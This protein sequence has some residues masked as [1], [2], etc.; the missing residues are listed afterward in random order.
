MPIVSVIMPSFNTA[1][2]VRASV[3][4]VLAQSF[5][6][7][8]LIVVDDG[9]KDGS[10][11][12]VRE[13][14]LQDPRINLLARDGNLGPSRARNDG[15]RVARGEFIAFCDSDDLWKPNKLEVQ[16]GLLR[17]NPEYD[18]TYC[19]SEIIDEDGRLTGSLFSD[20]HPVPIHPSGDLFDD[21]CIWNFINIQTVLL[22]RNM[23]G[24]HLFFDESLRI[25][26]D[27]WLWICLSRK[28]RFL[29]ETAILAQ[30]RVHQK[31]ALRT[32]PRRTRVDRWKLCKRNLRTHSNLPDRIKALLWYRMGNELSVLGRRRLA[33]NFLS[34]AIL[35][36]FKGGSSLR[37]KSKMCARFG[38]ACGRA[39][40]T[41]K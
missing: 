40:L 4:S 25:L 1:R 36:G 10:L 27:W 6:D 32:Q 3:E 13:L 37:D 20:Q 11:E 9:S 23:S 15:L 29:Y 2:Y 26:E 35:L 21:L 38:I 14:A 5:C 12:I 17:K 7:I 30:Y 8:E 34:N 18:L 16:I 31:S 19:E 41:R 28:H 39:L 24:S 33:R 22:R